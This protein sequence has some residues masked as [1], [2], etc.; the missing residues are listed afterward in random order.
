MFRV[1]VAA[2]CVAHPAFALDPPPP[3]LTPELC[4]TMLDA[5]SVGVWKPEMAGA[6]G[7][8]AI[9][10]MITIDQVKAAQAEFSS[11]QQPAEPR[12]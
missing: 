4:G 9:H 12:P 1:L 10:G 8:C 6:L 7:M 3:S 2:A 5:M 11:R